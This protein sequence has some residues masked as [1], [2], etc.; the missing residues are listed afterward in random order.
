MDLP[1]WLQHVLIALAV[2]VSASVVL[3]K[4]LPGTSRQVRVAAALWL[5]RGNRVPMLRK[6]GRRIAPLSSA[7]TTTCGGCNGCDSSGVKP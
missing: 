6:L 7:T 2:A 1:L 3:N 5:L 4:Q